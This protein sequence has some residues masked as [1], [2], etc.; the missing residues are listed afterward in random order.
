MAPTLIYFTLPGRAEAAR[1][2]F[3]ISGEEFQ[4]RHIAR[5]IAAHTA[6]A[7]N[8]LIWRL[9]STHQQSMLTVAAHIPTAS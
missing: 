3:S 1:L 4:V 9:H 2:M 5:H 7:L 8:C 6:T